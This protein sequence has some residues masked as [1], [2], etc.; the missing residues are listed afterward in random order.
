[1]GGLYK[2][3]YS[4]HSN[5]L[6]SFDKNLWKIDFS[7]FLLNISRI[8]APPPIVHEKYIN[9]LEQFSLNFRENVDKILKISQ[10]FLKNFNSFLVFRP[11]AKI[12]S[13]GFLISF[14]IIKAFQHSLKV[15]LIFIQIRLF[16]SKFANIS[17]KVSKFC[18]FLLIF[19]LLF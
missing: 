12:S 2:S 15:A 16:K 6:R 10:N 18:S 14:K 4:R 11:N 8:S 13:L 3:L 1:M 5:I 9:F 19:R 7:N 17:C